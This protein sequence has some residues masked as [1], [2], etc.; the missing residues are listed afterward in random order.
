MKSIFS[1]LQVTTLSL[2]LHD[3]KG[4]HSFSR[5]LTKSARLRIPRNSPKIRTHSSSMS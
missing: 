3:N 5:L 1:G 2:S 4:I